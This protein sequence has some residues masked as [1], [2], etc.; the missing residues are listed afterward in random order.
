[1]DLIQVFYPNLTNTFNNASGPEAFY[2][3]IVDE[4][5]PVMEFLNEHLS[6]SDDET[7]KGILLELTSNAVTAPIGYTLGR[8]TGL[9]RDEMLCAIG[10][11]VLWPDL[12]SR[13]S[14]V[15][16]QDSVLR[17]QG[18]LGVS[19]PQWLSM[20]LIDR[21][22]LAGLTFESRWVSITAQISITDERFEI[23]IQSE[24]PLLSGD[25]E[26]IHCRFET[27]E[28]I[29]SRVREERTAFEDEEGI[30]HMPSFTGGGGMGL[31]ACI[32]LAEEKN[33]CLDYEIGKDTGSGI[34]FILNN[35]TVI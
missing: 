4:I 15:S 14:P 26:E 34:K 12:S 5:D 32:R 11:S 6:I 13:I 35:H 30:Y 24:Y 19:I 21:V 20:N 29:S 28:E 31:L 10:T 27:P 3:S 2:Y 9:T 23:V 1:M 33:L 7:V 22:S 8:E 16:S 25:I 17:M 18:V